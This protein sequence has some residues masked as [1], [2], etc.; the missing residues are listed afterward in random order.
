MLRANSAQQVS[1]GRH[2]ELAPELKSIGEFVIGMH[3]VHRTSSARVRSAR[4][5]KL[6][7]FEDS[8]NQ[9]VGIHA[10]S[11]ASSTLSRFVSHVT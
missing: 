7:S 10:S 6:E 9:G 2:G 8:C 11:S 3:I 4:Q 1:Q 5:R